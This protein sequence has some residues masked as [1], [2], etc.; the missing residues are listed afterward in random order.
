M[1]N[2]IVISIILPNQV[3][4]Y[5]HYFYHVRFMVYDFFLDS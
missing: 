5:F 2:W 4:L 1:E 3:D